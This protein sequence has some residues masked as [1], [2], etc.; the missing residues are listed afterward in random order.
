MKILK[1]L[2]LAPIAPLLLTGSEGFAT[3]EWV[4]VDASGNI[5]EGSLVVGCEGGSSRNKCA[6]PLYVCRGMIEDTFFTGKTGQGW[7]FCNIERGGREHQVTPHYVL[8]DG[9]QAEAGGASA[10]N[11]QGVFTREQLEAAVPAVASCNQDSCTHALLHETGAELPPG[12]QFC[13]RNC[14]V[15]GRLLCPQP[16][17]YD[18]CHGVSALFIYSR[19]GTGNAEDIVQAWSLEE[20]SMRRR[21]ESTCKDAG[22]PLPGIR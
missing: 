3:A 10:A 19:Q 15:A 5:P 18:I 2:V 21:L 20:P 14:R 13:S 17:L 6:G 16:Q 1:A 7:G 8:H 4:E 9:A 12:G 22:V 11:K